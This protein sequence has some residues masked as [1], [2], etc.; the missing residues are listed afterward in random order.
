MRQEH[1]AQEKRGQ[2]CGVVLLLGP[3]AS[4]DPFRI[5]AANPLAPAVQVQLPLRLVSWKVGIANEPQMCLE[6]GGG[7][8]LSEPG[9]GAA[10]AASL[11]ISVGSL[12][13]KYVKLQR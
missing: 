13:G 10:N 8:G 3:F 11:G 6:A 1:L 4:V 7:Q 5:R 2:R 12:E 9:N